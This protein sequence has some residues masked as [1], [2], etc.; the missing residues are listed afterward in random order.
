MQVYLVTFASTHAALAFEGCAGGD[1]ALV[2]VPPSLRAGCGMAWRLV[3]KD[4]DGACT[5]AAEVARQAGLAEL[6]W[7]LYAKDDDAY[8]PVVAHGKD[9]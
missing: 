7:E 5:S 3:R 1:G 4:D 6:D 2:P 9:Q 8:R